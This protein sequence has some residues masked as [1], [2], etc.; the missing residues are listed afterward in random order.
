MVRGSRKPIPRLDS[1]LEKPL[2]ALQSAISGDALIK[3]VF[4][5][6]KRAVP[7]DFVNVCLRIVR[8]GNPEKARAP[9][10]VITTAVDG[11]IG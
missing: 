3:A 5:L 10:L 8:R 1:A 2:V 11:A 7:C 4:A 9:G 6:L